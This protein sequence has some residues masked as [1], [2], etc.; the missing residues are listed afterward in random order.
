M[1]YCRESYNPNN[2]GQKKNVYFCFSSKKWNHHNEAKEIAMQIM[3][4]AKQIISNIHHL[5]TF[6]QQNNKQ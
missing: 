3:Y 6:V 2:Y 1:A 5:Q 4:N